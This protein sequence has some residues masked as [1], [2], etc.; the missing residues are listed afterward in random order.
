MK[1]I[2]IL[3]FLAAASGV[4]ASDRPTYSPVPSS[5][6]HV[7]LETFQSGDILG[8][9]AKSS[10]EKYK[11]QPVSRVEDAGGLDGDYVMM[12]EKE[13]KHYAVAAE[14]EPAVDTSENLVVQYEVRFNE[15]LSCGGAYIKLLDDS[16]VDDLEDVDN[17]TPYIIMF[18]PDKCGNTNK[19][20]LILRHQNPISGE[21]EE[22]HLKNPPKFNP[23]DISQTFR[24]AINKDD[25]YSVAIDGEVK[26][27]GSLLTDFDPPL[28][29]SE[30]IDDPED[31]KPEDWVDEAKIP[32][33]LVSKPDDWDEDAPMQIPDASASIPEDWLENEPL[34]IP[35]PDAEMPEDWDEEEDGP[36]EAPIISNPKCK[37]VSGC[38]EWVRP[39]IRNPD[40]KGKWVRPMMDNPDYKGEW[41]PRRIE[42]PNFFKFEN[43]ASNPKGL[44]KIG[45]V[46]VEVWTMSKGLAFDNFYIGHDVTDA[47]EFAMSTTLLKAKAQ[48]ATKDEKKSA[49]RMKYY[50][51]LLDGTL[52]GYVSYAIAFAKDNVLMASGTIAIGVLTFVFAFQWLCCGSSSSSSNEPI[53]PRVREEKKSQDKKKNDDGN[54]SIDSKKIDDV[55]IEE[56]K[57]DN[58]DDDGEDEEDSKAKKTT[59]TKKKKKSSSKKRSKHRNKAP[60]AE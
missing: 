7:F 22:K 3:P 57:D 44:A 40:Y 9:F 33:M 30:E 31:T 38:G 52:L 11:G 19:V 45:A 34:E 43:F 6:N 59:T 18:G 17:E 5:G 16:K 13:A 56:V 42:N 32:N 49:D 27:S 46:A 15:G 24:L 14:I 55:L 26:S 2:S 58:D 51:S 25:T 10:K 53:R 37:T 50:E 47:E 1:K 12:F 29:P 54:T 60:R 39:M 41:K 35:D 8:A 23:S 4:T 21:W 28:N 48:K 36:F 20:H